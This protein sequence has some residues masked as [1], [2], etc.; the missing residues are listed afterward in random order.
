MLRLEHRT[1]SKSTAIVERTAH[2][3]G[4]RISMEN[5]EWRSMTTR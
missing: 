2:H 5:G 3:P 1:P 4:V